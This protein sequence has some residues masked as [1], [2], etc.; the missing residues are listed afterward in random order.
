MSVQDD[1]PG[2]KEKRVLYG[3]VAK[4]GAVWWVAGESF[5]QLVAI[6][7][8]VVLARLLTPHEFGVVAA[9]NFF[10]MLGNRI[11][12][13]GLNAALV[14]LKEVREEHKSSVLVANLSVGLAIYALLWFA[15][16][17]IGRFYGSGEIADVLR[18]VGVVFVVQPLGS[19]SMAL[20]SRDLRIRAGAAASL[21]ADVSFALVA[22]P[23]AWAGFGYWSLAYAHVAAAVLATAV[24]VGLARWWPRSWFSMAAFREVFSFGMGLFTK[25]LIDYSAQNLDSLIV[26]RVLG[27]T[28]LGFYDK[29]FNTMDRLLRRFTVAPGVSFRIFALIQDDL[30]RF[31]AAYLKVVLSATLLAFPVFAVLALSAREFVLVAFGGQWLP[32]V[33]PLQILCGAAALKVLNV[34]ASLAIQASGKVWSEVWRQSTYAVLIV[35]GITALSGWG[36]AGAALAVLGATIVGTAL[37]QQLASRLAGVTRRDLAT[38]L[39]P[40]LSCTV[41][42]A[43]AVFAAQTLLPGA[44]QAQPA[45]WQLLL[46]DAATAAVCYLAVLRFSRR[47]AVRDLV[48]EVAVDL[49]PWLTRFLPTRPAEPKVEAA[50]R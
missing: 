4:H 3:K 15:A 9:A 32:A 2:R 46:C 27:I 6:P 5:A 20:L 16:P 44:L 37:L 8:V 39:V 49:A 12:A 21:S 25:R 41:I 26:G 36:V 47:A 33:V 22:I 7:T 40:G 29:A 13:L 42:V 23:L 31:R 45:P 30:P 19:V 28:S 10:S 14:R 50:S 43:V 11:A 17:T 38:A 35:V 18:V 34:Y 1:S 48:H 24:R